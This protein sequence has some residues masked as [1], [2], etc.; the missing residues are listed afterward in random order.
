L[1]TANENGSCRIAATAC[2]AARPFP[3]R[4]SRSAAGSAALDHARAAP[5]AAFRATLVECRL[6][7]GRQHQI[8]IHLSERGHP[9]VGSL[10]YIR[11]YSGPRIDAPRTMLHART[12]GFV[13]PRTARGCIRARCAG[14][15]SIDPERAWRN[16][17]LD[18]KAKRVFVAGGSR[19]IGRSIALAFA[20][21]GASVSICARGAPALEATR[22]ELAAF[23]GTVHAASL[24]P[25]ARRRDRGY[26]PAAAAGA[27]RHR[28]A[29]EQRH[30]RRRGRR[31]ASWE[32]SLA[33][34]LLA[35]GA[36]LA[37]G[38]A[39]PREGRDPR[40]STSRRARD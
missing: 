35:A 4:P 39:L 14:G 18:V 2:A 6:E 5:R 21:G 20:E 31:R 28:R 32:E 1:P 38:A 16:M 33:V 26:V 13:H 19:G 24:R 34:D 22:A 23:G 29:G 11:D 12:L 17:N 3:A 36:R 9:L 25:V 27:R 8:R 10:V 37:R 15:F 40:S 30:R 7:T